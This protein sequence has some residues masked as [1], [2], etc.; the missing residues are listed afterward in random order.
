MDI[1]TIVIIL[2]LAIGSIQGMIYGFILLK[3]TKHNKLANR[4]LATIL[5]LLSYRLSIQIMRLFGLGYYDSWYYV[6]IDISWI[7]GALIYFYTKARTQPNFK[8]KK[9]DWIHFLPVIV[10]ICCSVFVRLQNIYWDGTKESLS[11]LGYY[12]YVVW[13]NNSTIYIVASILI[14]GYAYKS[15]KLVNSVNEKIEIKRTDPAWIKR[16]ITSFL[17]YFSLVLIVLLVDLVIYKSLNN[18]SYF[19]FT[20]FYYYPFFIGIAIITYWIGLEGFSRRN[21]PKLTIKTRIHPDEFERLK[22][23]SRQLEN[24]M[25]NDKLFKDQELSLRS[26]SER[27]KIKP[28]LISKSLNE[29]YNKRFNDFVNE[30]RVKEVQLLLQNSN[31]S[32]YTLLSIAMDAGFNSKSSFNRA[33]KKQLGILPSELKTKR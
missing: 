10:Q 33:V 1:G 4:I 16:I 18:G 17:V 24:A 9:K 8:F 19:Y 6:M 29:I 13:M 27:L 30:Y 7:Y 12:G 25:E 31:S 26:V 11:W 14:I 21:D 15:L 22:D 3:S 5:L 20:R 23:I 28:Y 2:L 32:K